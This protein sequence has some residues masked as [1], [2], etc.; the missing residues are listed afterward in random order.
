MTEIIFFALSWVMQKHVI[1]RRKEV[2]Y[3][4]A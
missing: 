2:Y 3:E 1:F 4:K